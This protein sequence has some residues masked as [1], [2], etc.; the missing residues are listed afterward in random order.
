MSSKSSTYAQPHQPFQTHFK[1]LHERPL[2]YGLAFLGVVYIFSLL[3]SNLPHVHFSPAAT[4]KIDIYPDTDY[5]LRPATIPWNISTSYPYPNRLVKQVSEGTW[6]RIATHP[7]RPEIVF[8]MLGDLYCMSTV[9]SPSKPTTAKPL[10]RGVPYDKEAEFSFDGGHIVFISDDG[11]GVDNIWTLP[12]TTCDEMSSKPQALVRSLAVQQTNS[13]FR[14]FSSPAFHPTKLTIVATKWYLTGRPNGAG[15]IW[16][17]PLSYH[18][19]TQLPQ[20]SGQRL[21]A[22]KLPPSW[23]TS[24]YFE[25][26]IGAEQARYLGTGDGIVYTRNIRDDTTGKFS[27][28]KDVHA[29]I[30]AVFL[31]NTTTHQTSL[32]VDANP[33]G[34]NM[35][36]LSRDG[37]TLAFVRRMNEKSVLVLK[38]MTSGTLHYAWKEL[39][40]DLSPIPAFMGAY[41][42]YGWSANGNIIIWAGGKIWT[43]QLILNDIGERV[44]DPK[45]APYI[46]EFTA[47]IDLAL[48][49]TVYNKTNMRNTEL[50]DTARIRSIRGLRVSSTGANVAF[51]AAGDTY[52][53]G[54]ANQS[55]TLIP[56]GLTGAQY[57]G[58]SFLPGTPYVLHARWDDED[59]TVLE[60]VDMFSDGR[61]FKVKGVPRGKYISPIVS[62]TKIALIRTGR[63]YILGDVEETAGAGVWVGD[64]RL[65]EKRENAAV[66]SNLTRIYSATTGSALNPWQSFRLDFKS[67][68][69]RLYLLIQDGTSV[70]QHDLH[71]GRQNIVV[72][73]KTSVE[74]VLGGPTVP[75]TLTSRSN[76][77][78]PFVAFRDFQH[79]WITRWSKKSSQIWSKPG[80]D[81]TPDD[82]VRLEGYS[83]H[84]ICFSADGDKIFWL[85][86]KIYGLNSQQHIHEE[87]ELPYTTRA[88]EKFLTLAGYR[89][90]LLE[91]LVNVRSTRSKTRRLSHCTPL[92]MPI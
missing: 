24:Q 12:Y 5:P 38:D 85:S 21:V 28:N 35:P 75:E 74:M 7:S 36:R 26:Q 72:Q 57:Y 77:E 4:L 71:T 41:P 40:Y 9:R 19:T 86:G 55:Q 23:H 16:E 34:A 84:D 64:I 68:A 63:D 15:E 62:G 3:T 79:A 59:L 58:P 47:A 6:L 32:V 37:R 42:N 52:I 13:T 73:G 17:I 91:I 88:P 22:R 54:I 31:F 11:F 45:L 82:L 46:L 61:Q 76:S 48:G 87:Q 30:N 69:E 39:D 1:L 18:P 43:V 20:H 49:E 89:L 10:L 53:L 8:D 65:P 50:S 90:L 67:L 33:G 25:S 51:E 56:K 78:Q 70:I 80:D 44:A 2:L 66:V 81:N 27:Y 60:L 14:F 92:S 29:G 83:G